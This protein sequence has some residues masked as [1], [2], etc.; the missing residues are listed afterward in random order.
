MINFS[1]VCDMVVRE[2]V[3]WYG[4]I[5]VIRW[6]MGVFAKEAKSILNSMHGIAHM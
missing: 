3:F 4:M 2:L 5:R 6:A 1:R